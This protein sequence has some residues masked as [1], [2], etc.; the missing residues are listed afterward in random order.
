MLNFSTFPEVKERQR[1][2]IFTDL[3]PH[4]THISVPC[5]LATLGVN[6][7]KR[8]EI[9]GPWLAQFVEYVTF[10]LRVLNLSPMLG[11]QFT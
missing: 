9:R 8:K 3:N 11:T 2:S 4:L 5:M 10:D 1:E 6:K 7:I